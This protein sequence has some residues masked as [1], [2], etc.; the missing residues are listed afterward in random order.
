MRYQAFVFVV[1]GF[2]L[3]LDRLHSSGLLGIQAAELPGFRIVKAT[4][5]PL[6]RR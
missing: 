3:L 4:E 6:D 1:N 2:G 5:Y